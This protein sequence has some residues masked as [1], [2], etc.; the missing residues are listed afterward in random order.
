MQK[1][2]LKS[3]ISVLQNDSRIVQKYSFFIE[4]LN[5]LYEGTIAIVFFLSSRRQ[6]LL[7]PSTW[8]EQSNIMLFVNL[9]DF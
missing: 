9:P 4:I 2:Y 8:Y 5:I 1:Y 3:P 7:Y 6:K